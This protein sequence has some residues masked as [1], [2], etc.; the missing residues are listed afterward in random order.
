[1]KS[2]LKDDDHDKIFKQIYGID[3]DKFLMDFRQFVAKNDTFKT[4]KLKTTVNDSDGMCYC[5]SAK[6]N[7]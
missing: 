6:Y 4:T 1:M 2:L 7:L 5:L 3:F